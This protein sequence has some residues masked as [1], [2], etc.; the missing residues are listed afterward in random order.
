MSYFI[1]D[2]NTGHKLRKNCADVRFA[3]EKG[4]RISLTRFLRT[5]GDDGSEFWVVMSYD[6][7]RAAFPPKMV[8][9]VNFMSGKTY[10]ESDDTPNCC[11]PSSETYWSM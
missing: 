6:E 9:R 7:H 11:S 3:T 4:A 1:V 5:G 8:K 2:K 10:M